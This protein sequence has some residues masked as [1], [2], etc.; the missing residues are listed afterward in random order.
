MQLQADSFSLEQIFI[1]CL[2]CSPNYAGRQVGFRDR[3][4]ISNSLKFQDPSF[5]NQASSRSEELTRVR[6]ETKGIF[7]PSSLEIYTP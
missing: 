6:A 3:P 7:S 1:E 5:I 2:L 4:S